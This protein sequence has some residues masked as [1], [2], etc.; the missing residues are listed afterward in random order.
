[1]SKQTKTEAAEP[2]SKEM[3]SDGSSSHGDPSYLHQVFPKSDTLFDLKQEPIEKIK[4]DCLVALDANVLLLPYQMN[5][6]SLQEVGKVYTTINEDARLLIPA[7]AA[8]EFALHR[9]SKIGE[10]VSHLRREA[11]SLKKPLSDKIGFLENEQAYN[12]V[13]D[14][15]AKIESLQKEF[16]K[17]ATTIA[18]GLSADIG[19]DPVSVIYSKLKAAIKELPWKD[20]EKKKFDE[21]LSNRSKYK[22]PPG[23][24]DGKKLDGGPGDLLIW[25]TILCEGKS[26]SKDCIFVTAE[27]KP[28]W[29]VRNHGAFQP[30]VE[31]IEEYRNETDGRTIHIIVLSRL[32]ELFDVG[33]ETVLTVRRAEQANTA[34][35]MS[36]GSS[37]A[38]A[39]SSHYTFIAGISP[40]QA[41]EL[42]VLRDATKVEVAQLDVEIARWQAIEPSL[43]TAA[44]IQDLSERRERFRRRI[45][46]I[47]SQLKLTPPPEQGD[48]N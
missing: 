41:S 16:R 35:A 38:H 27:E 37:E 2:E 26:R 12:E 30:R 47:D 10:I 46:W 6:V 48:S 5:K 21:D 36:R 32:L 9:A 14:V 25:K 4:K 44:Q 22:I 20:D 7:Q 33:H 34:I 31:L 19:S 39:T 18:D 3:S 8:R 28:D 29:W 11:T 40:K 17:K 15:A 24:K 23:Y 1:M 43:I 45:E 42:V 13:K